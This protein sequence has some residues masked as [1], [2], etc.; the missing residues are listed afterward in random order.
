MAQVSTK[1][2][3]SNP[4]LDPESRDTL[5]VTLVNPIEVIPFHVLN[6]M[7]STTPVDVNRSA[8]FLF[9]PAASVIITPC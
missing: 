3:P 7:V 8:L 6:I 2:S 9:Q 1:K 5:T 4:L